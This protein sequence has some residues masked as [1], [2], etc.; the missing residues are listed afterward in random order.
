MSNYTLRDIQNTIDHNS[1]I[2]SRG[3]VFTQILE[4]LQY[5]GFARSVD[6]VFY[7]TDQRFRVRVK[8]DN[9]TVIRFHAMVG[10]AFDE[11]VFEVSRLVKMDI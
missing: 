5:P 6:I 4:W 1:L 7:S 11:A 8:Q 10:V 9:Y 2:Y 3:T